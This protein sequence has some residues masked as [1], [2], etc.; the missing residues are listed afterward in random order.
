MN[1]GILSTREIEILR[2]VGK[3]KSNKEIAVELGISFNTVKVHI[4]NIY[5]KIQVVSRTEATLYAIEHGIIESPA[6][7]TNP[8]EVLISQ[9]TPIT[10]E[11]PTKWGVFGKKLW[12][13]GVLLGVTLLFVLSYMV[14]SSS[15]LSRPTATLDPIYASL[16]KQDWEEL[17]AL[18]HPRSSGASVTYDN[19]VFL[20]AG[21]TSNGVTNLV[22]RYDPESNAWT[23]LADKATPVKDVSAVR[24]G[25][26]IY[27]PGGVTASGKNTR[28]L[29]VYDPRKDIWELKSELPVAVSGYALA[30][31]E[32]EMYLFGGWD[33]NKVLD[34]VL[35]YDPT[36]DTW[37]EGARMPVARAYAGIA[38]VNGAILIIGGWDGKLT[39]AS[40]YRY[41]PSRD[42]EGEDA[43][44]TLSP[45]IEPE[46]HIGVQSQ[47]NI[48]YVAGLESMYQ[49]NTQNNLWS[50]L[51]MDSYETGLTDSML[52]ELN[53]YLY[54]LGGRNLDKGIVG[55]YSRLM[56]TYT[57]M[58]PI[59]NK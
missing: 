20:I 7:S 54:K 46:K 23:Q 44:E 40:C 42:L 4:A 11:G 32:G 14:S 59:I 36:S 30:A 21:E 47:T 27:V 12:W 52:V 28:N 58:L 19:Y 8:V 6:E 34:S 37:H 53:G 15:L 10:E 29:E 5:Q 16:L 25:E 55:S 49:Y 31:Y 24:I 51:V 41:N 35:R 17:A 38:Q 45:L 26:K 13:A 57:I 48:V 50:Q 43:W 1:N 9:P 56:I 22:E 18:P 33:G 39:M 3:G 2:L